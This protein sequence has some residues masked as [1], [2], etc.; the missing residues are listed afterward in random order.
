MMIKPTRRQF[1]ENSLLST[2]AMA[3]A[4]HGVGSCNTALAQ[5]GSTSNGSLELGLVTY[6]WGA[7]WDLPT[8]IGN[9]Q[10]TGFAGAELRTTHKHGVEVALNEQQRKEVKKR[11]E[12]ADIVL[13]GFGSVC[14]YHSPDEKVVRQNI[15]DTKAWVKLAHDCGASGVKVR[16]NGMPKEVP[17]E[18][19]IEQIG[20]SLDE[21]AAFGADYGVEIRL[22]I[23]GP[24]TQDIPVIKKIMEVSQHP[25]STL[26]WN[27]NDAD[28]KGEGLSANFAMVRDRFGKTVHIHDLISNYPWHAFFNLLKE[29]NYHGWTLLEEGGTSDPIRAMKYYR[30]VWETLAW[31]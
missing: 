30:K 28:L 12:D 29:T 19:T 18:K 10:K 13:V 27:C 20:K 14:E 15:E 9:L 16:P 1:F 11:F 7:D 8:L 25:N 2:A 26:C 23:H 3:A 24:I 21:C 22:E 5:D 4:W 6:M 17:A 31:S